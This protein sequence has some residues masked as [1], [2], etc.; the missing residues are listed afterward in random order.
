MSDAEAETWVTLHHRPAD[1]ALVGQVFA[2]PRF[3]GHLAFLRRQ[4]EAGHLVAAGSFGDRPGDGMTV[5]R[6]PGGDRLEEARR[7]ATEDDTSVT[8]G[9]FTVEVRPWRVVLHGLGAPSSG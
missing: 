6:L 7:W 1:P 5:L 2:D 4:Q 8:D 3:A 9:L